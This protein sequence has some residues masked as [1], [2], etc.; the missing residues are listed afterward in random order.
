MRK[1]TIVQTVLNLT[2]VFVMLLQTSS[3]AFAVPLTDSRVQSETAMAMPASAPASPM[4]EVA[5]DLVAD[6]QAHA[7]P[8]PVRI[9]DVLPPGTLLASEAITHTVYLPIIVTNGLQDIALAPDVWMSETVTWQS[10]E[11]NDVSVRYPETLA[12]GLVEGVDGVF[13]A[14]GVGDGQIIN[15]TIGPGI[16]ESNSAQISTWLQEHID[17]GRQIRHVSVKG[18]PS[19]DII[20]LSPEDGFCREIL[21]EW[22]G[23]WIQFQLLFEGGSSVCGGSEIFELIVSSLQVRMDDG[24]VE[25]GQYSGEGSD[26]VL[27]P[28]WISY[29]RTNAYNYQ[30]SYASRATN[31]DGTYIYC[32]GGVPCDGAHYLAHVLKNGGF[33]IHG[34]GQGHSDSRVINI[35]SQRSYLYTF[36]D[37]HSTSA[38]NLKIGDIIYIYG[39][40]WCWGE[41]V[42]ATSGG[43]PYVSTHSIQ[44]WNYRYDVLRCGSNHSYEFVHIDATTDHPADP[45]MASDLNLSPATQIV[46]ENVTSSFTVTNFGGRSVTLSLRV[47]TNGASDYATVSQ[48]LAA[49]ASYTYSDTL[50]FT[51]AGLWNTCAQ[52][53]IGT[54][55][56]QNIPV[57]GYLNCK[58]LSIILPLTT[59]VRLASNLNVTPNELPH[60]GGS[61]QAAFVVKNI[62]TFNQTERFRA[63]VTSG[64]VAFTETF[65]ITLAPDQTYSYANVQTFDTAGVYEVMAEHYVGGSTN[66]WVALYGGTAYNGSNYIRV[67]APPPPPEDIRKGGDDG[68]AGEPVDTATGNYYFC[69]VDLGEPT[70]GL[71]LYATRCYNSLDASDVQGPFG[72]GT[73]WM[74]DMQIVWRPDKSALV[75]MADG[76]VTYY[77]GTINSNNPLDMSGVYQAQGESQG[78]LV[79][80]TDGT[81]ILT[82]SDQTA[83]HFDAAGK[84]VQISHPY[85]AIIDVV[86][87]AGRIVQ[88][89]HSSGVVFDISYDGN[90]V[91]QIAS[92]TGRSVSYSYSA[93][94]DLETVTLPD[95]ATYGFIYDVDHRLVAGYEPNGQAYV[96]N[97]YD[98]QGRV[99][100][101]YDQQN[102]P[103]FFSY[104]AEI[105]VP[106][107][108]TD[109]LGNT[110]THIYNANYQLVQE[111]DVLGNSIIYTHDARGNI[112]SIQDEN[113]ALWQYTYDTQGNNLSETDPL[114]NTWVYVYDTNNNLVSETDPLGATWN[115]VYDSN[116]HLMQSTDPVGNMH[117]YVYDSRGNLIWEQDE[118]GAISEYAYNEL[119]LTVAITDALGYATHMGY[120]SFGNQNV[121]TDANNHVAYFMYDERNQLVESIDPMGTVITFTYDDAGNVLTESDGMGHLRYY[122]YNEYNRLVA[123]TD[124]NGNTTL[125]AYDLLGRMTVITDAV[126]AATY[127]TYDALGRIISRQDQD[128][129]TTNYEYDPLGHLI[130]ETDALGR[131][132]EYI[133]D[134]AG[135]LVETRRPCDAC[136]GGIAVSVNTYDAVGNLI[137]E[138]DP[139]GAET[140]YVYDEM[141]RVA[142]ITDTYGS[143]WQYTYN[144]KGRLVQEV[145]PLA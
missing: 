29:N 92:S 86:Y 49:G 77:L 107:V 95:G 91:S 98:A 41:A 52:M 7:E 45:K 6:Q 2:I 4:L 71:S 121:Y 99:I 90:Y 59:D 8:E 112:V 109:T 33:P 116:G 24:Q 44:S 40:S 85:P 145:N 89:V 55:E 127:F 118:T 46:N 13:T 18:I 142:I 74:F 83:Y 81:A 30:S 126:G 115:Y 104:G 38:K 125:Y 37:V 12:V 78:I 42:M 94:G 5:R 76:E 106:R 64:S 61:S 47:T 21:L 101:Q 102:M 105:T 34:S 63:L 65:S 25:D 14:S 137:W 123:E 93:T 10:I 79:R 140:L 53:K 97:V 88:L 130:R 20:A 124:F 132:A 35:K 143:S 87:S 129:A 60:T 16:R 139:R 96:Q 133:Y 113:G 131:I 100:I 50:A 67:L 73:S 138:I 22:P 75:R 48:T 54:G 1:Q 27:A 70:S 66:A 62:S 117:Q 122:S 51:A 36:S 68:K 128:G 119:G 82:A 31:S 32:S 15:V 19:W 80:A 58:T 141:G 28:D 103:S 57:N 135:R 134:L 111:I 69:M 17:A 43:V 11:M 56:W 39:G 26:S 136:P 72:Y 114:G 3:S 110:L 108:Y 84:I 9:D 120:D 144:P 23:S